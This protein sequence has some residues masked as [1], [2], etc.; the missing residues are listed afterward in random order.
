MVVPIAVLAIEP[1]T[2]CGAATRAARRV[3][4]RAFAPIARRVAAIDS[5]ES[6]LRA[7]G[8]RRILHWHSAARP[9][10]RGTAKAG[11]LH[12]SRELTNGT[13]G[14]GADSKQQ[15][16]VCHPLQPAR[17]PWSAAAAHAQRPNRQPFH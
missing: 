2:S 15:A 9:V 16:I 13:L 17:L 12:G 7:S 10:H 8:R 1:S 5:C 6:L 3:S 11:H 4:P 14:I